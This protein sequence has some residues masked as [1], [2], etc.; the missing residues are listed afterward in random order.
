MSRSIRWTS[1][2]LFL[3]LA[4]SPLRADEGGVVAGR[5]TDTANNSLQGARVHVDP[6]GLTVV[7]DAEGRFVMSGLPVGS[8]TVDISYV[9]FVGDKQP[10][11]VEAAASPPSPSSCGR[12]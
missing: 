4:G 5:V 6:R 8:Y 9:G 3:S 10:V 12:R 7:T 2:A 11:S 1:F